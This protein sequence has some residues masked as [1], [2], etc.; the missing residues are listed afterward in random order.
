[1]SFTFRDGVF[2]LPHT[3]MGAPPDLPLGEQAEP[4]LNQIQPGG[5]RKL[6]MQVI[7][8]SGAN[9]L[10]IAGVLWVA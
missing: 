1:M 7:P 8:R 9:P 10:R 6:E 5:M 2:Q 4:T 3:V